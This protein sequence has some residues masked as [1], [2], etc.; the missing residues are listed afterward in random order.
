MYLKCAVPTRSHKN[1]RHQGPIMA[2]I[3]RYQGPI[4]AFIVRY[5]GPIMA[6]IVPTDGFGFLESSVLFCYSLT[7][8]AICAITCHGFE[9]WCPSKSLFWGLVLT[10]H[11]IED[12][13][14]KGLI[15]ILAKMRFWYQNDPFN[16]ENQFLIC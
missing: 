2:F 15:C 5:Q 7:R 10:I 1:Q 16:T 13:G 14:P 8:N 6:F 3:V 4:M 9:N 12:L 11:Q